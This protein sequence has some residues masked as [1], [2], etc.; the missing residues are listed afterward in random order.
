MARG[1]QVGA[2]Q[3]MGDFSPEQRNVSGTATVSAG[4]EEPDEA[5]LAGESAALVE[6]LDAD[7]LHVNAAAH[8]AALVR[9]G[10]DKR[11]RL[12]EIGPH[13]RRDGRAVW[14]ASNDP[15]VGIGQ[16]AETAF[17]DRLERAFAFGVEAIVARTEEGKVIVAQ[18]FEEGDVLVQLFG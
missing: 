13:L 10:D 12:S 5:A 7:I 15:G 18:P 8:E 11:R 17:G 3:D 4:R 14:S 6:A 2:R 16:H 9:L 1:R